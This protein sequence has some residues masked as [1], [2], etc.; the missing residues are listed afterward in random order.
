MSPIE[1]ISDLVEKNTLLPR[2]LCAN[3][4]EFSREFAALDLDK[5]NDG[6]KYPAILMDS[7]FDEDKGN[8]TGILSTFTTS[9]YFCAEST[10]E[11]LPLERLEN[12]FNVTLYPLELEFLKT[13]F[14]STRFVFDADINMQKLNFIKR[15]VTNLYDAENI[16]NDVIDVLKIKLELK[17]RN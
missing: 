17:L 7:N 16:N 8:E 13:L 10:Q 6:I 15:K 5:E 1:V 11:A 3:K 4:I 9:F 2:F 12:V 14:R